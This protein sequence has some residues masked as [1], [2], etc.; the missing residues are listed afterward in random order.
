MSQIQSGQLNKRGIDGAI[1]IASRNVIVT[2]H[3]SPLP[4]A[5]RSAASHYLPSATV[6]VTVRGL[7]GGLSSGVAVPQRGRRACRVQ[8]ISFRAQRPLIGDFAS[9][10]DAIR[11][12]PHVATHDV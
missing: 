11:L 1:S 5:A 6:S 12:I 4:V 10:D 2:A 9:I 3:R 8:A 7:G